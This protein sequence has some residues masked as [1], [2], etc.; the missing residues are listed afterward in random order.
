MLL[1]LAIVDWSRFISPPFHIGFV[2]CK[3]ARP[4]Y[5]LREKKC[6]S[7]EKLCSTMHGAI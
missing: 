3:A 1:T 5:R 6:D 2:L 4:S 7:E